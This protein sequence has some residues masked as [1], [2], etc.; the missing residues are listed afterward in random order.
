M[1]HSNPNARLE[2][3]CDGVFAIAL[4]LLVIDL[5][6]PAPARVA[7]TADL[8]AALGRLSPSV[9]A[10]LLSFVV[11]FITWVNHHACL[12]LVNAQSPS[13]LYANG[14]L[15]LTVVL[16]PFPTALLGAYILTDHAGPA[17]V[18]YDAVIALQALG[19][20]LVSGAALGNR[21]TT[22][23]AATAAMRVNYKNGWFALGAY[24][25]LAILA[26]WLPL[27]VAALTTGSW[28]YWLIHGIRM[29]TGW[30]EGAARPAPGSPM[31]GEG[32]SWP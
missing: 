6:V 5:A 15:L 32:P 28:I 19:W 26:L 10:F 20:I 11:I 31:Q 7:S 13:F 30:A 8:W 9:F 2:A 22:D 29:K 24:G 1:A 16:V 18:F 12:R 27:T 25:A 3:F 17:V 21:L 23:E 14:L 4:T